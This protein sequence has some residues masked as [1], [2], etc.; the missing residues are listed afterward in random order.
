MSRRRKGYD[1]LCDD[2]TTHRPEIWICP[3]IIGLVML[4]TLIHELLHAAF[5]D[6]KE[7]TVTQVAHDIAVVLWDLGYT[8]DWDD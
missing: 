6:L 8:A 3:K 2:V 7:E 5:P 1:G 4:E